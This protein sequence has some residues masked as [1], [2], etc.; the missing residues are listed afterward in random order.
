MPLEVVFGRRSSWNKVGKS[1]YSTPKKGYAGVGSS[2]A[3]FKWSSEYS[4]AKLV[5]PHFPIRLRDAYQDF[6]E[7]F[8]VQD[9]DSEEKSEEVA[10]TEK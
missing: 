2:M 5:A 6:Y 8:I 1:K 4:L 7:Q 9:G 3:Y 10:L